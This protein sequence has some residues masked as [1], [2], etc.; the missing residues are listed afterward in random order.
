MNKTICAVLLSAGCTLLSAPDDR[1]C[2]Y[3][4]GPEDREIREG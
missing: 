1:P 4:D 3:Y 2:R